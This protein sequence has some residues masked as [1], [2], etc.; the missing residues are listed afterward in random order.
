[1]ALSTVQDNP[2]TNYTSKVPTEWLDLDWSYTKNECMCLELGHYTKYPT[3]C[4]LPWSH[5]PTPVKTN[6]CG[7][8]IGPEMAKYEDSETFWVSLVDSFILGF[9]SK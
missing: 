4:L 3:N 5:T 8:R 1:M 6:C 7:F 2:S 9:F